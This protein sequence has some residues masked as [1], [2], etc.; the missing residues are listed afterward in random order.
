MVT[1]FS[2]LNSKIIGS[3]ILRRTTRFNMK[4]PV[5][6]SDP[7][8]TEPNLKIWKKLEKTEISTQQIFNALTIFQN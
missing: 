8:P 1:E 4:F 5:L 3:F 6:N 2:G 7:L